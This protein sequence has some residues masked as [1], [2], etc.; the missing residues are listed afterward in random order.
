METV[1]HYNGYYTTLKIGC[2]QVMSK[3]L[4]D[5]GLTHFWNKIKEYVGNKVEEKES[6]AWVV[7]GGTY[8]FSVNDEGH[9]MLGYTGDEVPPFSIENGHLY[10]DIP[11]KRDLGSVVGPPGPK[12]DTTQTEEIYSTNETRIGT[13]MDGKPLYRKCLLVTVPSFTVS[14]YQEAYDVATINNVDTMCRIQGVVQRKNDP[15]FY[16]ALP[17]GWNIYLAFVRPKLVFA[18]YN[19]SADNVGMF[20]NAKIYVTLEYTKT[21]D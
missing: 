14:N 9:L 4:D 13:W 16:Q 17:I 15:A 5:F 18:L 12:G 20:S 11:P 7:T 8:G 19:I 2:Q 3:F 10:V 6:E 1:N 21:T